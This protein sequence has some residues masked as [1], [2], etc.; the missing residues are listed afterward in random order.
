[1]QVIANSLSN[2][3]K[4]QFRGAVFPISTAD[5]NEAE[6]IEVSVTEQIIQ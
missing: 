5:A 1:V 4:S 3:P 2:K 6:P